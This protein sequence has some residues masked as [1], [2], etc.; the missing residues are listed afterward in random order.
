[1]P[2]F[3]TMLIA[4][5]ARALLTIWL[6]VTAVFVILRLSGDPV[7]LLLPPAAPAEKVIAL[8]EELGLDQSILV[9]YV[10]FWQQV[11]R[12]DFG[13][14]L[15]FHQPAMS[16]VLER[17]P[18]TVKLALVAFAFAAIF[19]LTIGSI[20][21]FFRGSIWDRAAMTAMGV[22]QAAPSFFL[23]IML[24]LLFSV[25]LKWLPT[26][27]YGSVEQLILPALTLS[28]L[29]LA[30]LARMTRASLLEVLR[31]DYIRTARAK[32]LKDQL[33]WSR[34]ALRNASLPIAT[35]FG[36]ELADLLTGAV[37]VETVFAW[38]GVG[39][40]AVDAVSNR[41][42]PVVQSAVLLM[43]LIYIGVNLVIDLCYPLLDPRIRN[44]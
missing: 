14:S 39:R 41:D 36:M 1:M 15:R 3:A 29:T 37:L 26:S 20:A 34:H 9:Q 19:G 28:A 13:D 24:I 43:A 8:R 21:A 6:V 22:L 30:S 42:Y 7:R 2:S 40:L 12:G 11:V 10:R 18:A 35:V 27:G 17:F 4:R 25:R 33:V 31:A 32:G 5:L 16:L 23:G 38:P 44:A